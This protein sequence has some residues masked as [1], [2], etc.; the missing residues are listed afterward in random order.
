MVDLSH[1][2]H[3]PHHVG[4]IVPSQK[5]CSERTVIFEEDVE[6]GSCVVTTGQAS[7]VRVDRL[8][9][10]GVLCAF[11]SNRAPGHQSDSKPCCSGWENT[12]EPE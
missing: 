1:C 7:T 12:I 9:K 5:L 3:K 2:A 6:I 10:S 4:D 11:E 8:Q